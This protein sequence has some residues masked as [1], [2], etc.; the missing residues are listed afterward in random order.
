MMQE[1]EKAG[2]AAIV[3]VLDLVSRLNAD[4]F[5]SL[6]DASFVME[7]AIDKSITIFC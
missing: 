3:K 7:N 4:F 5:P 2:A 1:N 6:F